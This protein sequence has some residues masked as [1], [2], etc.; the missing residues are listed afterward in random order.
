[1]TTEKSLHCLFA[2]RDKRPVSGL[3]NATNIHASDGSARYEEHTGNKPNNA[4]PLGGF[5][6]AGVLE[7][8]QDQ[9]AK[10][11]LGRKSSIAIQAP[12]RS[13]TRRENDG[14][15][16]GVRR[17]VP[18]SFGRRWRPGRSRVAPPRREARGQKCREEV[19]SRL[20]HTRS[21]RVAP[22][23]RSRDAWPTRADRRFSSSK[24]RNAISQARSPP[25]VVA[26]CRVSNRFRSSATLGA[27]E[28]AARR[29]SSSA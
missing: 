21:R 23:G 1:M 9:L 5:G 12:R 10:E 20:P 22:G 26:F 7:V 15:C 2:N 13:R 24:Y 14:P 17:N 25:S 8:I 6:G 4:K 3:P 11:H 19:R 28:P 29:W 16:R 27:C 18:A